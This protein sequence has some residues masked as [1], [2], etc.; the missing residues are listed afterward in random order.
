MEYLFGV[1]FIA[2]LL[3]AL[4]IL[5]MTDRMARSRHKGG[6]LHK[7]NFVNSALA[8]LFLKDIPD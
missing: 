6:R 7:K 1:L 8:K 3:C 4:W 5:R 2:V